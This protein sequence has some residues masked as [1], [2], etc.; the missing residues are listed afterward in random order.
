[1]LTNYRSSNEN[2]VKVMKPEEA[3]RTSEPQPVEEKQESGR[4]IRFDF[5][6]TE[7]EIRQMWED[8]TLCL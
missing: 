1:M 5:R 8:G 4:V 7:E 6:Y 2:E 3:T